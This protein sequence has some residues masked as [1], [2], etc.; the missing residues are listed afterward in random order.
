MP[1]KKSPG[2]RYDEA[3]IHAGGS[4][5]PLKPTVFEDITEAVKLLQEHNLV[6]RDLRVVNIIIDPSGERAKQ[7]GFDRAGKRGTSRYP[8][9]LSDE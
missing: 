7:I 6:H 3:G 4:Q 1:T 5:R 8:L 2:G 9:A